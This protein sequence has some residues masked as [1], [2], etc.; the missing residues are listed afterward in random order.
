[1]MNIRVRITLMVLV[2]VISWPGAEAG[3][4][5]PSKSERAAIC[6]EKLRAALYDLDIP[7]GLYELLGN[8]RQADVSLQEMPLSRIA[9]EHFNAADYLETLADSH[10]AWL[11]TICADFASSV[12]R[13][14]ARVDC[15]GSDLRLLTDIGSRNYE[16]YTNNNKLIDDFNGF[17]QI[18]NEI[19]S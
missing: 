4:F 15:S 1:M 19:I 12:S 14:L 17:A 7:P 8:L 5:G 13:L 16:K 10:A 6:A 18:A 2:A 3:C 11:H 9:R